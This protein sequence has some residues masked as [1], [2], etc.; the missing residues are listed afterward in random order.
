MASGTVADSFVASDVLK[1][2]DGES[3][4]NVAGA[5]AYTTTIEAPTSFSLFPKL[6]VE[7]R[8]NIWRYASFEQRNVDIVS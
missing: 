1:S 6:P 4:M 7:L 3:A 5:N 2:D 8:L